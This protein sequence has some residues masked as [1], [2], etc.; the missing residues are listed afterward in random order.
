M[1]NSEAR[2]IAGGLKN[3]DTHLRN[4]DFV[5]TVTEFQKE[6]DILI[7]GKRGEAANFAK[8]HLGSN[9]ERRIVGQISQFWFAAKFQ[10]N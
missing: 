2:L 8:L 1:E 6:A 9:L 3:I 7:I 4:G 10:T 5:D